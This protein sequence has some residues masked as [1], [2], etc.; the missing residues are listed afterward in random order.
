MIRYLIGLGMGPLFIVPMWAFSFRRTAERSAWLFFA[1][2]AL[3]ISMILGLIGATSAPHSVT[4]AGIW[5]MTTVGVAPI[6]ICTCF[7]EVLATEE[8]HSI[9][10]YR[11]IKAAKRHSKLQNVGGWH[12]EAVACDHD[13]ALV[14]ILVCN[15]EHSRPVGSADP[16]DEGNAF[17]AHKARG[18]EMAATLNSLKVKPPASR[19]L[20]VP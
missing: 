8:G 16:V 10:R 5:G 7:V 1:V 11:E 13:D 6:F 14:E 9:K 12:V 2:I 4:L 18:E 15:G 17:H 19:A 3:A 20:V